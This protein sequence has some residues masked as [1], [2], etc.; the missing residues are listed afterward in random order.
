MW[1]TI[2]FKSP[3]P[4]R[5]TRSVNY[6]FI[7]FNSNLIQ[8]DTKII[9]AKNSYKAVDFLRPNWPMLESASKP[10]NLFHIR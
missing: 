10:N 8:L 1:T 5:F 2:Y 6:I 7:I 4:I 9:V 3:P